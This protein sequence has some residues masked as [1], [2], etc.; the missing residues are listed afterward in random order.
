MCG[1]KNGPLGH[2]PLVLEIEI[3]LRNFVFLNMLKQCF[4]TLFRSTLH[5][6]QAVSRLSIVPVHIQDFQADKDRKTHKN[7]CYP[8]QIAGSSI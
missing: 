4:V 2:L 6:S 5:I 1:N 8:G 3:G 7:C